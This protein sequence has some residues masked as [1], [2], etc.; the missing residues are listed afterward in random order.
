MT[1]EQ[2]ERLT[3][4]DVQA[5]KQNVAA[6]RQTRSG[7][8]TIDFALSQVGGAKTLEMAKRHLISVL[9]L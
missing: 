1:R 6:A 2:I 3:E 4:K 9:K 8:S 7:V 5:A